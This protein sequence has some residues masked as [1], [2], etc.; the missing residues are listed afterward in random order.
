MGNYHFL[1]QLIYLQLGLIF[2]HKEQEVFTSAYLY[3]PAAHKVAFTV[4]CIDFVQLMG[5]RWCAHS[6][7]KSATSCKNLT[8]ASWAQL[9]FAAAGGRRC[10]TTDRP[11]CCVGGGAGRGRTLASLCVDAEHGHWLTHSVSSLLG[12][13][14]ARIKI[15]VKILTKKRGKEV[16]HSF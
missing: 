14:T 11:M 12:I 13:L 15:L 2:G 1:C 9:F 5:R 7:S 16:N 6:N 8:A 3:T 4:G 10:F